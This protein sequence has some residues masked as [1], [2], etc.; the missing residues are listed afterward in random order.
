MVW[1]DTRVW[2]GLAGDRGTRRTSLSRL[3]EVYGPCRA[4]GPDTSV[5]RGSGLPP[6]GTESG[7]VNVPLFVPFLP[8]PPRPGPHGGTCCCTRRVTVDVG[9]SPPTPVI[10]SEDTRAS[11][12]GGGRKGSDG[13]SAGDVDVSGSPHPPPR[14]SPSR[15]CRLSVFT[16]RPLFPLRED[17]YH[18]PVGRE[19]EKERYTSSPWGVWYVCLVGSRV[20]SDYTSHRVSY[21]ES[22]LL[23]YFEVLEPI[24]L[25]RK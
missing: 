6:T 18:G 20:V 23:P 25:S 19:R 3:V 17:V 10:T 1:P 5:G 9:D 11:G 14:P 2:G 22:L 12:R 4:R 7:T 13:R 16:R 24:P 21:F 8:F 15:L